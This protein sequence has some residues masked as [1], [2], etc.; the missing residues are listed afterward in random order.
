MGSLDKTLRRLLPLVCIGVLGNL[1]YAWYTSKHAGVSA[2]KLSLG[3]LLVA[4]VLALLPWFWHSLRLAI[5]GQFFGVKIAWKHLFRIAVATDLGGMVMPAAV[6]GAP[7]KASMLVQQGYRPGQAATLTLW[8]NLEDLL[9]YALAIPLALCL[10]HNWDNPLWHTA[11]TIAKNHRLTIFA[12]VVSLL[13]L[14]WLLVFFFKKKAA[15]SNRLQKLT[16]FFSESKNAFALIFSKGRKP[17]FWSFLAIS[18]QWVTRFCILLA[19]VRMLGLEADWQRLFLLQWMVFVAMMLTPTPGATG[20][21]EVGFLLVFSHSLPEG[22]AGLVLL[23]WRLIS[24]YF[25]LGTGAF[26]LGLNFKTARFS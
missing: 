21:A 16:H 11:G 2:P 13:V 24:Y 19:V 8:G 12:I 17:C 4:M 6:G 23:G 7:L 22:M 15:H 18:A 5:W 20:G 3:W 26:Y 14:G 1:C 10:T 25:M 9:F